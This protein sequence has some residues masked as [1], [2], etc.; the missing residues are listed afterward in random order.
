MYNLNLE[1]LKKKKNHFT[2]T[3]NMFWELLGAIH[4]T[5]YDW[6]HSFSC[7]MTGRTALAVRPCFKRQI[8]CHNKCYIHLSQ[9][10]PC[11]GK[12]QTRHEY[13]NLYVTVSMLWSYHAVE[14]S[15][16]EVQKFVASPM[17]V[18]THA[19]SRVTHS[20]FS[21]FVRDCEGQQKIFLV[22][23]RESGLI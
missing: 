20:I 5:R 12:V 13:W 8:S 9:S 16:L 4:L 14:S 6:P 15:G 2:H 11:T 19:W 18:G 21:S 17:W 7:D 10:R 22:I 3:Q 23:V 1:D